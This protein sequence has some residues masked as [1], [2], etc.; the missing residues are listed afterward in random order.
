M[1]KLIHAADLHLDSPLRG[2]TDSQ[3][4]TLSQSLLD[5]PFKIAKLCRENHCDLWLLSGDIFDGPCTKDSVT[6]L[7][8]AFL[9]A[10]CPVFIAPGNH[11]FYTSDSPWASERWP[12]NVHIF[13]SP[14]PESVVIPDLNCRIYG[15]AF[16]SMDCPGLLTDFHAAGNEQFHIG[17]FHG[18]PT[19]I[20]SPYSPI[21]TQQVQECGLE[22]LALGHIHKHNFFRAG[23]TLCAWPGCPMGRGY[24]ETNAKGVL[25]V[26]IEESAEFQFIPLDVPQFFDL[27]VSGAGDPVSALSAVLPP[28]GN[29]NFYRVTFTG[30]SQGIDL[31]KLSGYF[32]HFPH[33]T[34]RDETIPESDLWQ[35]CQED[36]LTGLYFRKLQTALDAADN[37]P[38]VIRLAAILSRRIL[39]GQEVQLP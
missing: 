10:G 12:E 13:T 35:A 22:Y 24:D 14:H 32:S 28:V 31:S 20:T 9:E 16:Q 23:S 3:R 33:L 34:L 15:A 2:F 8:N 26:T 18:D 5:I 27:T 36:T 4:A 6:A 1:I 25:L 38:E 11:D 7:R 29:Q 39:D 30:Y 37:D 21:T 19:Q 17:V